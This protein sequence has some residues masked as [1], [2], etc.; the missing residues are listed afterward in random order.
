M[1]LNTFTHAFQ[2]KKELGLAAIEFVFILPILLIL[3][4]AIIDFGR[5]LFQYDTL[6]KNTRDATRYLASIVRPPATLPL[7]DEYKSYQ[8]T[9]E[10]SA[11]NLAL[12]GTTSACGNS[13]LVDGLQASNISVDYPT[14]DSGI[15]FVRVKVENFSTSYVTSVLGLS[16]SLGTISVTMRQ[17]QQ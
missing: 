3:A 16:K 4:F 1:M 13:K 17:V 9:S 14:A 7:S 6:T 2:N 15:N 12:C 8:D 11:I 5:L 10:K